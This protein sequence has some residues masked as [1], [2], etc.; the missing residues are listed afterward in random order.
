MTKRLILLTILLVAAASA[1]VPTISGAFGSWG[2]PG[3][4]YQLHFT[5]TNLTGATPNISGSGVSVTIQNVVDTACNVNVTINGGAA[6]GYRTITV[7]TSGGTSNGIQFQVVALPAP[8]LSYMSPTSGVAGTT[9]PITL[10]GNNLSG[11]SISAILGISIQ[12][13]SSTS[14]QVTANFV[15]S[16]GASVGGKTVSVST[17]GG[18]SNAIT[19]T[20]TAPSISNT[21]R[22]IL[23]N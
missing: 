22:V 13:Q 15:I 18:Y 9:V 1:A 2:Y 3:N 12:S 11:A 7:T 6:A 20:V 4:T 14:T 19:F 23:V 5:G 16:S 21:R 8:S 10:T 17:A